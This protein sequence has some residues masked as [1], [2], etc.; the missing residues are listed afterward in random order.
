VGNQHSDRVGNNFRVQFFE[1]HLCN[2][3]SIANRTIRNYRLLVKLWMSAILLVNFCELPNKKFEFV[4]QISGR[5]EYKNIKIFF[6]RGKITVLTNIREEVR[7]STSANC[8]D[9]KDP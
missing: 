7:P 3:E 9:S 8:W 2:A 6:W 4:F 5:K 1:V